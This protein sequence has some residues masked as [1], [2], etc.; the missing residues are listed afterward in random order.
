MEQKIKTRLEGMG[1]GRGE[2]GGG[3]GGGGGKGS[4]LCAEPHVS[5][6]L[7][8]KALV[9][10]ASLIYYMGFMRKGGATDRSCSAVRAAKLHLSQQPQ[11][12]IKVKAA[13]FHKGAPQISRHLPIGRSEW[14]Q[15]HF[16]RDTDLDKQPIG[17]HA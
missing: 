12:E 6:L 14:N 16:F 17:F 13:V 7:Q 4:S 1:E 15:R 11:R 10:D 9:S 5:G 2:G 3:G 8:L